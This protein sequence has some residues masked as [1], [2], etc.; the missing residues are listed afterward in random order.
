V[1]TASSP[2]AEEAK[3][4]EYLVTMITH[5]PPGTSKEAED[6]VR[7]REAAHTR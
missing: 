4:V 3:N 5:V 2:S 6:D 1:L 7:A